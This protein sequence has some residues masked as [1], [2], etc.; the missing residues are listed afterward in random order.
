MKITEILRFL[1]EE[2]IPYVFRGKAESEVARF[3][4]SHATS[5]APLPG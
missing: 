5:P 2:Q 3:P 4:R 1:D